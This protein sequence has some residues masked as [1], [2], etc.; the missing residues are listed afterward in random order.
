VL[1]FVVGALLGTICPFQLAMTAEPAA[2]AA[3]TEGDG[4]L[5]A[6]KEVAS[7]QPMCSGLTPDKLAAMAMTPTFSETGAP[8]SRAPSPMT[9]GRYDNQNA[10]Y[11]FGTPGLAD[12]AFF[13]AGVGMWQFDSAGGWN[14]TAAGAINVEV[15][16]TVALPL[17]RQR[18]CSAS[19][20]DAERR[21]YAWSPWFGCTNGT[22][23]CETTFNSM[24]VNGVLTVDTEPVHAAGGMELR[25]C[26][27]IGIGAVLCAYVD[28]AK[29]QGYKGFTTIPQGNGAS[30]LTAPFYVFEAGGREYR[31]WLKDDT[32]LNQT[33]EAD[34]VVTANA[35]TSLTWRYRDDLCDTTQNRGSCGSPPPQLPQPPTWSATYP[36]G[37][38]TKGEVGVGLNQD[39]RQELFVV[40]T[41]G[42]LWHTW[43]TQP[44]GG[45]WGWV[46]MGGTYPLT[47]RPAVAKNQDGRMEV[48]LRGKD[49]Q[50]WHLY[51]AVPNGGW[52]SHTSL[53]GA[54]SDD[55]AVGTNAD[56]R[57]EVFARFTDSRVWHAW[58]VAPNQY[59]DSFFTMNGS[60]PSR[61]RLAVAVNRDGRIELFGTA[62]DNQVWH[63]WQV[64]PNQYFL[65]WAPLGGSWPQG[66]DVGAV[67]NQDGRLEVFM[68]GGD[69][70][71]WHTFQVAPNAGWS[72]YFPQGTNMWST[73]PAVV[74]DKSGRLDMA[75]LRTDGRLAVA[76]QLAPNQSWNP[77]QVLG[78]NGGSQPVIGINADGHVEAFY[79]GSDFTI[80]HAWQNYPPA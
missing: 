43:Q 78:G 48:F 19:G 76:S 67:R 75:A 64:A 63:A 22:V 28:P 50:L 10:L 72:S 71:M 68:L 13:H 39:G 16:A 9:L 79:V 70:R 54:L 51:Q 26:N 46:P 60:W 80:N 17:I 77:G 24:L 32:G 35:R 33:I 18:F 8:T 40:G 37:G 49:N 73:P 25:N 52:S 5:A 58:Q 55:P 69:G 36:F 42:Q 30:P 47:V 29:A 34:K 27:V 1:T 4:P 53:G 3:R 21:M 59:F 57:I 2:A 14:L 11:A 12:K 20:T 38:A 56:G 65:P 6:I 23:P 41:D 44:N 66:R 7:G 31:Y 15:S 74:R 45:W 61:T 62:G